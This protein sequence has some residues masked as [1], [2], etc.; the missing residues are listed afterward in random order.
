M[1]FYPVQ[2]EIQGTAGPRSTWNVNHDTFQGTAGVNV[3]TMSYKDGP[4]TISD[5]YQSLSCVCI[6]GPHNPILKKDAM[7]KFD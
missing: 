1:K 3:W 4:I 7:I 5:S 6:T 2:L